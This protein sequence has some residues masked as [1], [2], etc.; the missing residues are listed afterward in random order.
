MYRILPLY[1]MDLAHAFYHNT[2]TAIVDGS[3]ASDIQTQLSLMPVSRATIADWFRGAGRMTLGAFDGTRM[4][5]LIS[6]VVSEECRVGYLSYISV[7]PSHRREGLGSR[8]CDELEARL[9]ASPG[10]EKLEVVFY[11]PVHIPWYIPRGDEDYHPCL[12]G[13]D[14]AS[15]LYILL[16][17]R[18]W[19]D[20]AH[21]NA[22][23]RRLS[24]YEDRPEMAA[25]LDVL[26]DEGI[27]L[28]LYDPARHYGL[29]EL[30]DNIQNSGWKA[31][32]LAHLDRPIVIAADRNT[33]DL[34]GRARIVAYT[35]PL[36]IDG[37][38]GRGNFCGIGTHKAYRS[39]GIGKQVFCAMCRTHRQNG[40][41]FMSLYT[42][43]D[44][45]ARLIYESAG[46]RVV[47]VFADM[48]KV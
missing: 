23:Y 10:V 17:N 5:G 3:S 18:G 26:R 2:L 6:G 16:Q 37:S 19:R 31:H 34:S 14:M 4:V 12:P 1:D 40:A 41:R 47:R 20:F 11:N 38:P 7:L 25:R 35:G 15:G 32:V 9:T 45:P 48:R 29:P 13:V 33:L 44:N 28:T 27:D 22:Y 42:G 43:S 39:R 24:D 21:Q 46:F 36:S 8:L 30:F